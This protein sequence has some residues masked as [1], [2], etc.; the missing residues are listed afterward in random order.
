MDMCLSK[1]QEIMKNREAWYAAVHGV[2]KHQT[3]LI[4]WSI[5]KLMQGPKS[6]LKI[7]HFSLLLSQALWYWLSSMSSSWNLYG[8]LR[9]WRLKQIHYNLLILFPKPMG[10]IWRC[11]FFEGDAKLQFWKVQWTLNLKTQEDHIF[12]Q[13]QFCLRLVMNLDYFVLP[14]FSSWWVVNITQ[15]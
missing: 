11:L 1:L 4:N 9:E 13:S 6:G 8:S 14:T 12:F 3:Q 15:F 5:A 2:T 10:Q 7:C